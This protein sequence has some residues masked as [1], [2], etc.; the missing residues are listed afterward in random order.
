MSG[1]SNCAAAERVEA[2]FAHLPALALV[3]AARALSRGHAA[4]AAGLVAR[5]GSPAPGTAMAR[6]VDRARDLDRLW[7]GIAL[8]AAIRDIVEEHPDTLGRPLISDVLR[9]AERQ[10]RDLADPEG[11]DGR[12]VALRLLLPPR[13]HLP[14][15]LPPALAAV[16]GS[17]LDH[18]P[19]LHAA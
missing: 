14:A 17:D 10:M 8:Q 1:L 9:A 15:I 12:Q 13:Q 16:F 3:E 4:Y 2:R 11:T 6:K 7:S 5:H 18:T 19:R